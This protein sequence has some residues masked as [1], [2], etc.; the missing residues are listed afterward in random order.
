MAT[1]NNTWY[2][3]VSYMLRTTPCYMLYYQAIV[4]PMCGNQWHNILYSGSFWIWPSEYYSHTWLCDCV[5]LQ[6]NVRETSSAYNHVYMYLYLV[7]Q[8]PSMLFYQ[9]G[10]YVLFNNVVYY[11]NQYV[12]CMV[13]NMT[14][15]RSNSIILY[16]NYNTCINII[17]KWSCDNPLEATP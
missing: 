10:Y 7:W 17:C 14:V 6:D 5:L 1:P 13:N 9:D 8:C 11:V 3:L 15:Q 2:I 16:Y 4:L 12:N